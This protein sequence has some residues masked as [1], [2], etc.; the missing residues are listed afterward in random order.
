M[1]TQ[2]DFGGAMVKCFVAAFLV[3]AAILSVAQST[4]NQSPSLKLSVRT[5]RQVYR[6]SEEM[7]L[8][9]Q[10]LN[11]GPRDVYIWESDLCWNPA[12]GFSMYITATKGG[13]PV[14]SNVLLDCLPPP[15]QTG[16]AYQFIKIKPR[17]FHGTWDALKIKDFVNKPGEYD[18]EVTFNS[19]LSDTFIHKYFAGD[20]IAK[21]PLWTNDKPPLTAP[22]VHIVVKP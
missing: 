2:S 4:S 17:E 11:V 3:F 21:L 19:F 12:R 9:T 8:E 16:D 5:D 10:V 18:I 6:L 7:I 14:S 20:P 22:L 15:P 13:S 1:I